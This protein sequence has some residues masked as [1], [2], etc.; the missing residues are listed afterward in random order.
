MSK[1]KSPINKQVNIDLPLLHPSQD[2][3]KAGLKRFNVWDCGRRFGKNV[4]DEDVAVKFMLDG[5]PVGWFEPTYKY[6]GPSWREICDALS[7]IIRDRSEQERRIELYTGG[8]LEM[9]SFDSNPDAGRSRKY[10]LA[11]INEAGLVKNLL[12]IWN[13]SIRATLADLRGGSIFSGTPKGLNDF[14]KLYQIAGQP[15]RAE[16]WAR[17]KLT[18]YDNPYIP[19]EELE[20]LKKEMPERVFRQE[21]MAE[22]IEDGGFFGKLDKVAVVKQRELPGMHAGHRMVMALDWGLSGDYTVQGVG[23]CDCNKVVDWER[24]NEMDYIYQR[25]K[26]KTMYRRWECES[27]MPE[28]NSMGLPNIEILIQDGLNV[29]DGVDDKPGF[30]MTASTKPPLIQG[31]AVA[32][33]QDNF[34]VPEEAADELRSFE[35]LTMA[36][37]HPKFSA[38]GGMHDDW[39]IMLAIL[40]HAMTGG[41]SSTFADLEELGTADDDFKSRWVIK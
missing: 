16:T 28:R 35:V 41:A 39:V 17:F 25:E 11:V 13:E 30:N 18:T 22:F 8:S 27:I 3:M 20:D 23:C 37:G 1:Q 34:Q 40:R 24:F 10:K 26:V 6:L 32:F 31:L 7:P 2:L 4:I 15:D 21:I 5:W 14:Y 38:P 29:L 19:K 9:W 33:E 36:S 12:H